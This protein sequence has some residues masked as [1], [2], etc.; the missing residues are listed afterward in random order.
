MDKSDDVLK[1]VCILT[2][3]LLFSLSPD[4]THSSA[5]FV[6]LTDTGKKTASS[7]TSFTYSVI[8][9]CSHSREHNTGYK[10]CCRLA[11]RRNI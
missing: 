5:S 11:F 2:V 6:A 1:E 9:E 7:R 10:F 4:L 8:S 3:W